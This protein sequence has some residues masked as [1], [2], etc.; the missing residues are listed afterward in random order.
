MGVETGGM[1]VG[2]WELGGE[3]WGLRWN[4]GVDKSLRGSI[5]G[6]EWEQGD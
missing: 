5:G 2:I 4:L 3:N 6:L 1:G